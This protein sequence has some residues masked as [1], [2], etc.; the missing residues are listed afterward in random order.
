M[1]DIR[2]PEDSLTIDPLEDEG[3]DNQ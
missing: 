2:Y 1:E 3:L